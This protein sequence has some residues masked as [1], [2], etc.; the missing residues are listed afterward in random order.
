M[1]PTWKAA[2]GVILIFILGWFGGALSTWII[3]HQR[4]IQ[5]AQHNEQAI[6]TLLERRTTRG[7]HLDDDKK[8]QIHQLLQEN[9]KQRSQLQKQIQPQVWACNRQ[10][11]DAINALLTPDQQQKLQDNLLLFKA[12]FGRNPLGTGPE[13]KSAAPTVA[14]VPSSAISGTNMS[15]ASN[16]PPQ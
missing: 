10:T 5:F 9:I 2:I 16:T 14:P 3:G 1:N 12:N 7:L 13:D 6:V 4:L 15:P 8:A 11:L